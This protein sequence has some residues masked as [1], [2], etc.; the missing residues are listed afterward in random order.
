M[1]PE[2]VFFSP[3]ESKNPGNKALNKT[4]IIKNRLEEID[5]LAEEAGEFCNTAGIEKRDA[6]RIR[7]ILEELIVNT[8]SYGY[9]DES[10]HEISVDLNKNGE[11]VE[12]TIKEDSV[13]FDPFQ[14]EPPDLESPLEERK[15]GGHGI[16]LVKNLSE[17]LIYHSADNINTT[18]ITFLTGKTG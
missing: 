11:Q 1:L 14:A 16:H 10:E 13:P 7:L 18:T 15:T 2:N 5:I 12:I 6:L 3:Y 9:T 17:S 8:I 4:I